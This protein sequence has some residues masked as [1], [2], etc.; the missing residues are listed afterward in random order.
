MTRISWTGSR[1]PKRRPKAQA[2]AFQTLY[3]RHD[4]A[5]V[6]MLCRRR[7]FP[8]LPNREALID[9]AAAE[10]WCKVWL[11][12]SKWDRAR[13]SGGFCGWLRTI[14]LRVIYDVLEDNDLGQELPGDEWQWEPPDNS[15]DIQTQL[16]AAEI[17]IAELAHREE[18]ERLVICLRHFFFASAQCKT[19]VAE[20]KRLLSSRSR[21]PSYRPS[22]ELAQMM[23]AGFARPQRTLEEVARA[24]GT[25][26]SRVFSICARYYADVAGDWVK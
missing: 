10:A 26:I 13:A 21:R 17:M 12:R 23:W 20:L 2:D 3:E 14:T 19:A 24:T 25:L 8:G 11:Y 7:M 6:R 4:E 5:M 16:D 22:A 15:V 18:S 9:R 1:N